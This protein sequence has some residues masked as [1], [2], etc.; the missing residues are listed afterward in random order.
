[1][2]KLVFDGDCKNGGTNDSN[3]PPLFEGVAAM[4]IDLLDGPVGNSRSAIV[5]QRHGRT[6]VCMA[7]EHPEHF[8][9]IT[10]VSKM[11]LLNIDVLVICLCV[12]PLMQTISMLECI[13]G[14]PESANAAEAD[15]LC[16][17]RTLVKR[18][19]GGARRL[20]HTGH[21]ARGRDGAARTQGCM[22]VPTCY[23]CMRDTMTMA[24]T[25][26]LDTH[27]WKSTNSPEM[28]E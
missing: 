28:F 16:S 11:S 19:I 9:I 5:F 4:F 12:V 15:R 1:M 3:G 6:R 20:R 25:D 2:W 10:P 22:H 26:R 14:R 24:W 21:R 13:F 8:L 17:Y 23:I 27:Y 18:E 7:V